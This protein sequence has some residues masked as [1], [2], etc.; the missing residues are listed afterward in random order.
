VLLIKVGR[1]LEREFTLLQR[2]RQVAPATAVVV[3]VETDQP[4]LAGLGWDLGATLV[5]TPP[6]ARE[7]LVEVVSALMGEPMRPAGG[8]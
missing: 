4:W 7:L 1:H 6:R 8:G 2:A 5:L 3:V